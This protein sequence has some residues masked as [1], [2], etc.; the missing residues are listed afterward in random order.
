MALLRGEP[1][2]LKTG[3]RVNL[4]DI[5][6][7]KYAPNGK[8]HLDEFKRMCTDKNYEDV[9]EEE[10]EAAFMRLN[11]SATGYLTYGEYLAWWKTGLFDD[12]QRQDDLKFQS[13]EEKEQ[14]TRARA[15][16]MEGTGGHDG[17][18]KDQ[19]MLKCYVAGYCLTEEELDEAFASIDK[20][21]NG[22]V[23]FIEYLRWRMQDDRFAHLQFSDDNA[24]YVH[25]IAEFFRMYD[26]NLKG[27]L[28]LQQFSPLYESLV[29][30]GQIQASKEEVLKQLN[31]GDECNPACEATV[32]LNDF[33]FWYSQG[34]NDAEEWQ[35][36]HSQD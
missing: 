17:M 32:K 18:T 13:A 4:S 9:A 1:L 11:T 14:I 7:Q 12:N 3:Q 33:V 19:F 23:D 36:C 35:H 15:S 5:E 27:F 8:M 31:I 25:Q 20:D 22:R 34:V 16:F 29:S 21:A 26:T 10:L 24:A 2:H 30:A 28:S 6:F